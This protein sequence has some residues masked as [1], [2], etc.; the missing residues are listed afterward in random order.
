VRNF[1]ATTSEYEENLH[2][3]MIWAGRALYKRG[4]K[5]VKNYK[6]VLSKPLSL[7]LGS[8]SLLKALGPLPETNLLSF[9]TSHPCQQSLWLRR[10]F[11][12]LLDPHPS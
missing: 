9:V 3:F 4:G 11:E 2:F 1:Q 7:F 12:W 6:N 8:Q 5:G 10:K